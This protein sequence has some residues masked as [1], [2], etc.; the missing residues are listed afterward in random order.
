MNAKKAKAMRKVAREEMVGNIDRELILVRRRNKLGKVSGRV[1]NEP[2]SVR[3]MYQQ[4]KGKYKEAM[5]GRLQLG[6][7]Q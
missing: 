1:A 7:A 4:L 2:L 3:A 5:S 6:N